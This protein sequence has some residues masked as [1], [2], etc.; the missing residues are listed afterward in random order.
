[1]FSALENEVLKTFQSE[2]WSKDPS[3][4]QT[5]GRDW[6]K[7]IAPAPSAI[8]FP[9]STHQVAQ[10]MKLCSKHEIPV[11]PSGGRTGLS[12]GAIAAKGEVVLSL[13][14]MRKM[15]AVDTLAQTVQVEAGAVTQAVHE[16]CEKEGLTWP[17]DFAS[18]G[19][20]TVGGNIAT[21]AGGVKVIRYGL[22][23]NW[24]LGLTVVTAAG[25]ILELGG[26]LEK[27]QTGM[28]LRQLF[29]GSEGTLGIVTQAT[30]KLTRVPG[31]AGVFFFG[32]KDLD[33]IL[34]LFQIARQ[35]SFT[36]NAFE[37]IGHN[38]FEA[39][40]DHLKLNRPF[41][42]HYPYYVLM[43]IE[44]PASIDAQVRLEAWLAGLFE[45]EVVTDG[46]LAQSPK[47]ARDLWSLR[48]GTA[49]SIM[50]KWLMH[51]HD[52]SVGISTLHAF[53]TEFLQ[54]VATMYHGFEV[55]LFGHIGDGNLHIN[56]RKPDELS[57]EEFAQQ[58]KEIDLS[59]YQLVK[60]HHGSVS[61]EH[62][63]GLMKRNALEYSRSPAEIAIF[64]AMKTALDPK[65]LVNPGKIFE[66]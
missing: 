43:E 29:I 59:L 41:A 63:I 6:T 50:A 19:S 47:E 48:E 12:G 56:I 45:N 14:R 58:C 26:D 53:T 38:C 23:R 16:H 2:F 5:Y 7:F 65:S 40:T 49:E 15:H 60:K 20:S 52:V 32:L 31:D 37:F 36:I 62:G 10:L 39:V 4:L 8:A 34:K 21:N 35:E 28:D 51:K 25:D 11:V 46:V 1:M 18:K 13:S 33:Q 27:N 24:V 30:L 9:T 64:R 22:T 54:V 42:A 44:K 55:F 66:T 3:D 61:A 57:K 17:V